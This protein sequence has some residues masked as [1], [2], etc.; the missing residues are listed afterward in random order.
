M[1]QRVYMAVTNDKYALP[2]NF[3]TAQYL[4]DWAGM[5][6]A[7]LYCYITRQQYRRKGNAAGCKFIKF[8]EEQD[9]TD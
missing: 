4:A 9:G 2:V 5:S 6:V 8:W 1:K 3:G 7:S